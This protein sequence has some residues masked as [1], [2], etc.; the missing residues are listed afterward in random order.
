MHANLGENRYV[1][2]SFSFPVGPCTTATTIITTSHVP[3]LYRMFILSLRVLTPSPAVLRAGVS[4]KEEAPKPYDR[5]VLTHDQDLFRDNY[6]WPRSCQRFGS[7][8]T[9]GRVTS[10]VGLAFQLWV[11][12]DHSCVM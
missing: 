10:C 4:S 1:Q 6:D 8:D 9:N 11:E 7:L 3:D 12:A 5:K 2:M